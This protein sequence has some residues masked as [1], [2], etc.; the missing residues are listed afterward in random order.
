M[1][2]DALG[3][4]RVCMAQPPA[5][6]VGGDTRR[7]ELQGVAEEFFTATGVLPQNVNWAVRSEYVTALVGDI[8]QRSRAHLE[9][10]QSTEKQAICMIEASSR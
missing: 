9:H 6:P 4:P 7:Q 5:H 1:S 10:L 3:S 8:P 2:V